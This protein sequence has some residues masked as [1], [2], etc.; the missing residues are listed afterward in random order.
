[1]RGLLITITVAVVAAGLF[2]KITD[3]PLDSLKA[4]AENVRPQDQGP[5]FAEIA[6]REVLEADHFY[7]EGDITKAKQA[8]DAVVAYAGRASQAAQKSGKHLKDTE[9]SLRETGRHLDDVRKTLSFEDRSYVEAA[10]KQVEK[11]RHQLLE[12]MFGPQSKGSS[13]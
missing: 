12:R 4:R 7:T 5:L 1:M 3:E 6:R 13:Q 11:V 2:A 10:V 9:I 8:V